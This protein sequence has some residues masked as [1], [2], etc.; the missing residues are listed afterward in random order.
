MSQGTGVQKAAAAT[1]NSKHHVQKPPQAVKPL[2][3]TLLKVYSTLA[4]LNTI[5]ASPNMSTRLML[6]A[7]AI[8]LASALPHLAARDACSPQPAGAGPVTSPDTA[9]AFSANPVYTGNGAPVPQGY[10]LA[11]ANLTGSTSQ[12]GYMGS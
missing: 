12:D 1:T 5:V 11:F 9:D 6:T 7:A 4:S 3:T 2:R 8:G 10:S